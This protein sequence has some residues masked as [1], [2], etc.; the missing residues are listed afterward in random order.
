MESGY[1]AIKGSRVWLLLIATLASFFASPLA[2]AQDTSA[3]NFDRDMCYEVVRNGAVEFN[4]KCYS[5][6]WQT[7]FAL[8]GYKDPEGF[9]A[10]RASFDRAMTGGKGGVAVISQNAH[11]ADGDISPYFLRIVWVEDLSSGGATI[12]FTPD[13]NTFYL[14]PA[15]S[16]VH[17]AMIASARFVQGQGSVTPSYLWGS[18][19]GASFGLQKGQTTERLVFSTF[20]VAYP[21][22]YADERIPSTPPNGSY[23]RVVDYSDAFKVDDGLCYEIRSYY[24][25]SIDRSC[26]ADSWRELFVED[27]QY[28]RPYFQEEKASLMRA[29]TNGKGAWAIVNSNRVAG[30]QTP[31]PYFMELYWTEDNTVDSFQVHFMYDGDAIRIYSPNGAALH[32]ATIASAKVIQGRGETTPTYLWGSRPEGLSLGKTTMYRLFLSTFPVVYPDNYNGPGVPNGVVAQNHLD[33]LALGDSYSSGEGDMG[34]K[35]NGESYYTLLTGATGGCHVSTRSYPFLLRDAWGIAPDKMQSVACSGAQII[36]D[37]NGTRDTYLGQGSRF[38][39][40]SHDELV[41]AKQSALQNFTP[42]YVP[43]IEFAKQ[44]QPGVITLTGGGNDVGFADI[45]KYCALPAWEEMVTPMLDSCAY[46]DHNSELYTLLYASIK[47]AGQYMRRLISDIKLASPRSR[48]IIVGYPKFIKADGNCL[49]SGA[50][51]GEERVMIN[52]AIIYMN[53]VLKSE[54]ARAGIEYADVE[55]SL[56]GGRMCEGSEYMTG[57]WDIGSDIMNEDKQR[58]LFHPNARGHQ[59]MSEQILIQTL[60]P[61]DSN[62]MS[63]SISGVTRNVEFTESALN[64]E[65]SNNTFITMPGLSFAPGSEV[66]ITGYSKKVSLGTARARADGSLSVT[67]DLSKLGPGYHVITLTGRAY[68]GQPATYY[69]FVTIAASVDDVDG[70]GVKNDDDHCAFL[71]TW[72]DE[73]TGKNI[74]DTTSGSVSAPIDDGKDKQGAT[75]H[76]A[77]TFHDPFDALS[78]GVIRAEEMFATAYEKDERQ[79]VPGIRAVPLSGQNVEV[80]NHSSPILILWAMTVLGMIVAI[81]GRNIYDRNKTNK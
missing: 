29:L 63:D 27:G 6:T 3:F 40:L 75:S 78:R 10:E 36:P 39:Y 57:V 17:D 77:L 32:S 73:T 46:T 5:Q 44:T 62:I 7:L 34:K 21:S 59:K 12:K 56:Y 53:S 80:T 14:D 35:A 28:D 52:E 60:R 37:Y 33:Y 26:Y 2:S 70:D 16:Q 19:S 20:P 49:N 42:G 61:A 30:D 23:E 68:S 25:T 8:D 24:G 38:G 74:C 13:G 69:Q 15:G 47:S 51:T 22:G 64:L 31:D 72:Y 65:T 79:L 76:A 11:F 50:L 67:A 4:K 66:T 9:E 81:I 55:D 48:I 54:A 18:S 41:A 1:A 45:L 71:S 58:S 43:Q